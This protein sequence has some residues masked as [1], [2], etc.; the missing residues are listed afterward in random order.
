MLAGT[1]A[2]QRFQMIA[3]RRTQVL[4]SLRGIVHTQT[5][6]SGIGDIGRKTP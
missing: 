6:A 4:Q 5:T 3:G 1:I 2:A